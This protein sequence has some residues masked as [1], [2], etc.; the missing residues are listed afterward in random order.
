[1]LHSYWQ[2]QKGKILEDGT[3]IKGTI[4][5]WWWYACNYI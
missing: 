1:M 5:E 2:Q 4:D 3:E